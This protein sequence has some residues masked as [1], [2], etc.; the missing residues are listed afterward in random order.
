MW[1]NLLSVTRLEEGRLN[2]RISA[3]LAD[4]VV[5]EALRHV[6]RLS[7]EHHITVNHQDD[8]LLAKM[9]A[10]LIVQVIINLVDNAIKYTPQGSE[11]QISTFREENWAVISV[12][13]NGPGIPDENKKQIFDMFYT[14][15]NR[16][17]DS[18]RSLGLGLSL[19]KSIIN[20]HGGSISVS[21]NVPHGTVFTFTLPAEEVQ[22]HE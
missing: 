4:E 7:V 11:I 16:V 12:A 9:D 6:N 3:E 15:S 19:C 14:G 21:D 13:D 2:L 1:K 10:K 5:T 8:L 17:V 20:A 18:R 22:L